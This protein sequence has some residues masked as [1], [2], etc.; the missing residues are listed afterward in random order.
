MGSIKSLKK[1]SVTGW[2]R[3]SGV[4]YTILSVLLKYYNL[5]KCF[6]IISHFLS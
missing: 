5:F 1:E 2:R 4:A 3:Y 6:I